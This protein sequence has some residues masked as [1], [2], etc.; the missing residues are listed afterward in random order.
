MRTN[1]PT[2]VAC[3]SP[4][5]QGYSA[6]V[7]NCESFGYS[8]SHSLCMY[9]C[10]CVCACLCVLF[11]LCVC[12]SVHACVC[13]FVCTCMF[14]CVCMLVYVSGVFKHSLV[15]VDQIHLHKLC[16]C[17]NFSGHIRISQHE[18]FSNQFQSSCFQLS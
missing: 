3:R 1:K 13:V 16:I 14:I 2:S 9:L 18:R 6:V 15:D 11:F 7:H 17:V 10:V 8:L 5:R 12:V 4:G